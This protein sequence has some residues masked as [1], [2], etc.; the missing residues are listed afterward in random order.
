[1]LLRVQTLLPHALVHRADAAWLNLS[2]AD[3]P[4]AADCYWQG[5]ATQE[6]FFELIVHGVL[7]SPIRNIR[8]SV[9]SDRIL[10]QL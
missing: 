3:W 6:P 9:F 5:I 7:F 2:E 8:L 4:R 1:M 10:F